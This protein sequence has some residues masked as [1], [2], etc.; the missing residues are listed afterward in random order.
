MK[1]VFEQKFG[2]K[3]ACPIKKIILKNSAKLIKSNHLNEKLDHHS[4]CFLN[5]NLKL[6]TKIQFPDHHPTSKKD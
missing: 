6:M 2:F 5:T 3:F 1:S 4:T